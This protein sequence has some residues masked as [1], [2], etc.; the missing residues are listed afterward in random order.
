MLHY[1]AKSLP[2][3]GLFAMPKL[4][5]DG[6]LICGD[7]GGFLNGM[8]LKGIHLAIRSGMLAAETIFEGLVAG[9]EF[10]PDVTK[11]YDDKFR[12]DWSYTELRT[13][14]NFH[15]GFHG[16]RLM[17]LIG[18]GFNI[19]FGGLG[20]LFRDKL[21]SSAGHEYMRTLAQYHGGKY[22]RELAGDGSL[23]L[24]SEPPGAEVWLYELVDEGFVLVERSE[25]R[26]GVTPLAETSLALGS[27]LV[28]LKKEGYR[29]TRY[30]VCITR[31]K[32]WSGQAY[33]GPVNLCTEEEIGPGFIYV[34]SGP[35]VMG[36]DP[37]AERRKQLQRAS[38]LLSQHR[39]DYSAAVY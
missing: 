35:F 28:I 26:L 21:K 1:G 22:A 12:A 36:G 19:L 2:E 14:R 15:Q 18:A 39:A 16:G 27:Y 34:P 32:A 3:G 23:T 31:N 30:P 37:V 29:D 4:Y 9:G 24:T 6:F 38:S 17:G 10:G 8:R 5:G 33:G 11:S 7:A 13:A 20:F 25:R